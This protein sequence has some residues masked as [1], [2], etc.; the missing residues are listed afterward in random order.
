MYDTAMS[1]EIVQT[2][3]ELDIS[4]SLPMF[5]LTRAILEFVLEP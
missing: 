2:S 4:S 5:C 3:I 1:P